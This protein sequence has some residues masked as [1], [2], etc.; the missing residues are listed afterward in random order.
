VL[1]FVVGAAVLYYS[2]L[3][4]LVGTLAGSTDLISTHNNV[5]M[6]LLEDGSIAGTNTTHQKL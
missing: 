4:G 5:Y 1:S 6:D 2:S 3:H